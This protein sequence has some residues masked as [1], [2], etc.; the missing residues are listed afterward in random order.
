MREEYDSIQTELE[1]VLW[2]PGRMPV[3]VG[4]EGGLRTT[5]SAVRWGTNLEKW[6]VN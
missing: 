4:M 6:G 3:Q 2:E 5:T 1:R